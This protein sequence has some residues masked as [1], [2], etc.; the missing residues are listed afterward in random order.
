MLR[1]ISRHIP[2]EDPDTL[3]RLLCIKSTYRYSGRPRSIIVHPDPQLIRGLELGFSVL[4]LKVEGS[5]PGRPRQRRI[6]MNQ[7]PRPSRICLWLTTPL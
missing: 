6:G 2:V 3:N 1:K 5:M 4:E 7:M